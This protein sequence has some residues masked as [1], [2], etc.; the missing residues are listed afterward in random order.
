MSRMPCLLIEADEWYPVYSVSFDPWGETMA[1]DAELAALA[2]EYDNA[3]AHFSE[4]QH[5]LVAHLEGQRSQS[6]TPNNADWLLS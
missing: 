5:K 1:F 2:A 6:D 3:L 4:V